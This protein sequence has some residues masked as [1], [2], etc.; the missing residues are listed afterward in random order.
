MT[1]DDIAVLQQQLSRF[2]QRVNERFD[3]VDIRLKSVELWQANSDN[4]RMRHAERVAG[5]TDIVRWVYALA[6]MEVTRW[7]LPGALAVL[8]ARFAG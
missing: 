4:E 8:Y 1:A 3:A 7:I 6:R 2:E 5:R